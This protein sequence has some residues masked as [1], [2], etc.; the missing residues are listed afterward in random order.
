MTARLANP[1]LIALAVFTGSGI[2]LGLVLWLLVL[3]GPSTVVKVPDPTY[4]PSGTALGPAP[5]NLSELIG[6]SEVTFTGTVSRI[7]G[8]HNGARV[9]GDISQPDPYT[10]A[11]DRAYYV[12]VETALKG[13]PT[14][15]VII[16][17]YEGSFTP[18][19]TTLREWDETIR[20]NLMYPKLVPMEVGNTYTFF[21]K[22][23]GWDPQLWGPAAEPYRYKHV[24]D[25][26]AFPE[27][28]F[29]DSGKGFEILTP[30]TLHD[31]IQQEVAQP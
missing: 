4:P 28:T 16:L 22:N 21:L 9:E 18:T 11:A 31:K 12:T 29:S 26:R 15:D 20:H 30:Q 8:T 25:G 10:Y 24:A 27:G 17:Q 7:G 2:A 19:K 5:P 1:R 13:S 23:S 3:G 14:S 6:G